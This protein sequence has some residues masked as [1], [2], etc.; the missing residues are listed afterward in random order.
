MFHCSDEDGYRPTNADSETYIQVMVNPFF[1]LHPSDSPKWVNLRL[2]WQRYEVSLTLAHMSPI[3][4][5]T[6]QTAVLKQAGVR[7]KDL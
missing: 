6:A 3:A 2:Y 5:F 4:G 7:S 1:W